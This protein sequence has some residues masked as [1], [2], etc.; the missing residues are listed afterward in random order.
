MIL[1]ARV[2]AHCLLKA[3][4][5]QRLIHFI[6]LPCKK[7]KKTFLYTSIHRQNVVENNGNDVWGSKNE[8]QPHTERN[9]FEK[10]V[11]LL[12]P[13]KLKQFHLIFSTFF[14]LFSLIFFF[15][16]LCDTIFCHCC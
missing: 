1:D 9:N 3:I 10:S 6:F 4:L 16:G 12:L 15:G 2:F 13:T 7:L 14:Y 11:S 8:S 5:I